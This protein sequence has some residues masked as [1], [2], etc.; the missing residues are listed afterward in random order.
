MGESHPDPATAPDCQLLTEQP[1]K[2]LQSMG[3]AP[4]GAVSKRW[5]LCRIAGLCGELCA[6]GDLAMVCS[7]SVG[8]VVHV[9][10]G[11]A[12]RK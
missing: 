8:P 4:G 5:R 10:A 3:K 6:R 12:R 11:K 1:G 9:C 7:R 2:D